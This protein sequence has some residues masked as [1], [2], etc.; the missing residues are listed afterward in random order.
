MPPHTLSGLSI[1]EFGAKYGNEYA[2][3]RQVADLALRLFDETHA[4]FGIPPGDR[5]LLEAAALLHD[6][7][8]GADPRGHAELAAGLVRRQKLSGFSP[9]EREWIANLIRF[10]PASL[11]LASART[12]LKRRA[13]AGR[14]IYGTALL[15]I[16]D[17]LDY[18]HLQDASIVYARATSRRVQIGVNCRLFSPSLAMARKQAALWREAFPADLDLRLAAGG[19]AVPLLPASISLYEGVRRLVFFHY[20]TMLLN[21]EGALEAATDEALHDL[22][23]AVRRIRSVL[24]AFRRPLAGTSARQIDYDLQQLNRALGIARDLDVWIHFFSAE[25]VSEQ[26][27]AHRLWPKFLGHQLELRRLQQ[28]TVRRQLHGIR[29]SALQF[30][31]GRFLR[32]QLPAVAAASPPTPLPR[33]AGRAMARSLRRAL[34]LGDLRQSRS[35]EKL[36]RL[37]IALRRLRYLGGFF[38]AALGRPI[39]KI[40]R[41]AHDVERLLGD[42]RDADL[43][44]ARILS[45]GPPPPRLLVRRLQRLRSARAAAV[46]AAW[47][48]FEHPRSLLAF[49]RQLKSAGAG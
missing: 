10:H 28:A 29:F 46:D 13:E 24:R 19:P 25:S 3:A 35:A 37:R 31:L 14:M 18:A 12:R 23:I 16:A 6:A 43:A 15:R 40:S 7:S 22:R 34:R 9:P 17:A 20:R 5:R 44:L 2:H 8:Y 39:R 48:R 27:T 47:A 33:A 38:E 36:H 32:V 49:R 1:V 42:M 41:R 11:D 30:R 45:E 26:F 21:V 4:I